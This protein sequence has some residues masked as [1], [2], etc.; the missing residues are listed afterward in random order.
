MSGIEEPKVPPRETN[1]RDTYT[2]QFVVEEGSLV[3]E[4]PLAAEFQQRFRTQTDYEWKRIFPPPDTEESLTVFRAGNQA[5][6][7]DRILDAIDLY[8]QVLRAQDYGP[9]LLNLAVAHMHE[10][11]AEGWAECEKLLDVVLAR[12]EPQ[13]AGTVQPELP[14][15]TREQIASV[16]AP[17]LRNKAELLTQQ[18]VDT[19]EAAKLRTAAELTRRALE[20]A[21]GNTAWRLELWGILHILDNAAEATAVLKEAAKSQEFELLSTHA[22]EKYTALKVKYHGS[23]GG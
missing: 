22:R 21:P 4:E 20:I 7:E 17:A 2:A 1:D 9:A 18:G 3:D 8:S 16:L 6:K 23:C 19:R 5:F 11:S 13:Y 10:A 12:Y 14:G 15:L